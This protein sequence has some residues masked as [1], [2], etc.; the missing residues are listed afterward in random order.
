MDYEVYVQNVKLELFKLKSSLTQQER[1]NLDFSKFNPKYPNKCIYGQISGHCRD[2][3]AVSLI[4]DCC[5]FY[6]EDK[7]IGKED[8][9]E[10]MIDDLEQKNFLLNSINGKPDDFVTDKYDYQYYSLLEGYI[11]LHK[12]EDI[13][14]QIFAYLKNETDE[15]ELI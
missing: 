1:D 9:E 15:L 13:I 4:V 5:P 8:Y 2:K 7:N 3:R 14:K 12:N 10:S 11:V 6:L